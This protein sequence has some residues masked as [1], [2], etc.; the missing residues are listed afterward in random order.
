MNQEEYYLK[1]AKEYLGQRLY[2][3]AKASYRYALLL[4]PV[5]YYTHLNLGRCLLKTEEYEEAVKKFSKA[6][7]LSPN[8]IEAY[9]G[10]SLT[11]NL[12]GEFNES[13]IILKKALEIS[14]NDSNLY[15][16]L[17]ITYEYG[18]EQ[19][20]GY[21]YLKKAVA[22]NIQNYFAHYELGNFFLRNKDYGRA[23][24]HYQKCLAI[25]PKF[26]PGLLRLAEAYEMQKHYDETLEIYDKLLR[27]ESQ[28]I[29]YYIRKIGLLLLQKRFQDAIEL[30]SKAFKI[31][32]DNT[33]LKTMKKYIDEHCSQPESLRNEL[34][35]IE[36]I[37]SKQRKRAR[38]KVEALYSEIAQ[39]KEEKKRLKAKVASLSSKSENM[40][41]K[42]KEIKYRYKKQLKEISRLRNREEKE[43]KLE[44][45][46][47]EAI[48]TAHNLIEAEISDRKIELIEIKK[49]LSKKIGMPYWEMLTKEAQY[50]LMTAEYLYSLSKEEKIDF[51]LISV[52]LSKA[53]E[54]ELNDKLIVPF[55]EYLKRN[56]KTEEFLSQNIKKTI[57]GRPVYYT[58]LAQLVDDRN[59]PKVKNLSL[60]QIG[61]LLDN[62]IKEFRG[63]ESFVKFIK[64]YLSTPDYFLEPSNLLRILEVISTK[65]RNPFAHVDSLD[66]NSLEA[67]RLELFGG[68]RK[69]III[70]L[71]QA[72]KPKRG[73]E[74]AAH[75]G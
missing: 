30:L 54:M 52:E 25:S 12:L 10:L 9:V 50:F 41:K 24:N 69:G 44:E 70:Q 65:Y 63:T 2:G 56:Q 55:I 49:E 60:G 46:D 42:I 33:A 43:I 21:V 67:F 62:S 71:L 31:E 11:H 20:K 74:E 57:G 36:K 68:F 3:K 19:G 16:H 45:F 75:H 7:S 18:I 35:Q 47:S 40:T 26:V 8:F 58:R 39:L 51:S 22:L 61:A 5:N 53:I 59:F 34:G 17:G 73:I 29:S 6:I 37:L 72:S 48:D 13:I 15:Y 4:N 14:P 27:I 1:K 28:E 66:I 38:E 64:T 32:P 23:I